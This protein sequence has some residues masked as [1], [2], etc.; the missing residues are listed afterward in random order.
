MHKPPAARALAGTAGLAAL[1]L[2]PCLGARAQQEPPTVVTRSLS[3]SEATIILGR[4]VVDSAGEDVGP[5]IDVLVDKAGH[6]I[7][8][9]IDVGGFFGVGRRRVAVAWRLLH[10]M[11]DNGE[12]TIHMDLTFDSAAAAPEFQGP[13][14]SL[15]VID[16]ARP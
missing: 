16:L 9:V 4:D 11:P 14:D 1:L 8:G 6:P 5:L 7:A 3:G 13:D 12:P 10:F 15:I 2:W